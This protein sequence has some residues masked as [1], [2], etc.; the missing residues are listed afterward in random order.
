MFSLLELRQS[1][2]ELLAYAVTELFPGVILVDSK[3]TEFGFSYDFIA[4]QP[5]DANAIHLIE[6]KVRGLIKEGRQVRSLEM[7]RENAMMLFEHKGQSIKA[8]IVGEARENIVTILQIDHFYDYCPAPYIA[9]TSEVAAFKILKI[10][11]AL[12]YLS[13][14]GEIDVVR[15]RGTAFFEKDLLKKHVKSIQAAKKVDHRHIAKEMHLFGRVDEISTA[16]WVWM[17]NG[18][19]LRKV[20]YDFWYEIHNNQRF[21]FPLTPSLVKES[22]IKKS[23]FYDI[24]T[25]MP[26]V[27]VCH[28]KDE[29]Y[30]IP[31]S[32]APSHAMCYREKLRSY[33]EMPIRLAECANISLSGAEGKLWGILNSS[34]VYS[35]SAHIFCVPAQLEGEIIS[36]LQ[37]I[38]KFIKIFGFEYHWYLCGQGQK[39]SGTLSR[40]KK[41]QEIFVKAF[42]TV[43]MTFNE[44]EDS[45]FA[46]PYVE[47]RLVDSAGR[48]WKGPRL[49][50]DFNCPERFSLR[51]QGPDDE[52][53][54][55]IML[56]R[57][58]FGS[59][60]RFTAVLV[61]HFAGHFPVWL[62]PEQVRV[63]P[64]LEK[65]VAYADTVCKV[66]EEYGYRTTIDC[67]N[68]Q[69][70]S[71]IHSA[72]NEK[73]PYLLI[74]GDK[75]EK[76]GLIT[77]RSCAPEMVGA[78]TS[79]ET[80][81]SQLRE[82]VQ[83]KSL[84]RKS[85]NAK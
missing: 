61:E 42:E 12:H 67:R 51:Y 18:A 28:I 33:R 35:D 25:N 44:G 71:K 7:M 45:S 68:E 40:W 65:N 2:A 9:E 39:F 75:E 14:E 57:S 56:V 79:I 13:E 83:S 37:F 81:L 66:I 72:E 26:D 77:V 53:H 58:L 64:V 4:E 80:F 38:D 20:L 27:G 62:A 84:P 8:H 69:L 30:V 31:P 15:I 11:R 46:G 21:K 85:K 73:I 49:S 43:S 22:L 47:A 48:K 54:V 23:G 32:L 16:A 36:S 6:E 82:E 29:E 5:I 17:S 74:V 78:Q 60:E 10:E 3:V 63:I 50:L 24:E 1:A 70:G 41:V 52:M 59:F 55:P 76:L 34:L 19:S